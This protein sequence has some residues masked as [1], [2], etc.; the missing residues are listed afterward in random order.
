MT[1]PDT[2]TDDDHRL[3][4][5]ADPGQVESTL[6]RMA[7]AMVS[8]MG[9]N[10]ALVGLLRRGAP[11]AHMLA[12]RI[13]A[14]GK[15]QPQVGELKL[16]RYSDDLKI[17]H[18]RPELDDATL[19]IDIEGRHLVIVD[20]VLYTGESMFRAACYLRAAGA[21][22]I[23]TAALCARDVQSMPV[24]GD[25]IGRRIDVGEGWVIECAIPPYEP[26]LGISI[27]SL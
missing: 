23:Q 2:M 19:D 14:L 4:H 11:I 26:E 22:R 1:E 5:L 21:T 25:F 18:D 8:H 12:A 17:L 10:T 15:P 20:D 13:G 3:L 9:P 24:R 16:K 27:A 6:D 7:E